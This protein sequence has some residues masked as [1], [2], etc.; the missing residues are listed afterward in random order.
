MRIQQRT[1]EEGLNREVKSNN[2]EITVIEV[3]APEQA[4]NSLH[5]MMTN[6]YQTTVKLGYKEGAVNLVITH[7]KGPS[8]FVCNNRVNVITVK[9]YV[10]N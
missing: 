2:V 5:R 4:Y 9:L 3:V 1:P 8:I 10:V 6:Q 7:S